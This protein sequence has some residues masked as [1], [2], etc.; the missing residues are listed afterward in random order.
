MVHLTI[1]GTSKPTV[2][3]Q[4]LFIKK[5]ESSLPNSLFFLSLC[6]LQLFSHIFLDP[7]SL[8]WIFLILQFCIMQ[9]NAQILCRGSWANTQMSVQ[10]LQTYFL[11]STLVEAKVTTALETFSY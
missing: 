3:L 4:F 8:P 1:H 5:P 10:L 11:K 9:Q 2:G 7:R 6:Q